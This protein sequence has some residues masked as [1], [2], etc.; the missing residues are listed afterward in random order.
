[1]CQYSLGGREGSFSADY[2][3]SICCHGFES[4]LRP[5]LA[6]SCIL[7]YLKVSKAIKFRPEVAGVFQQAETDNFLRVSLS[8]PL[9]VLL[10]S[11]SPPPIEP[12]LFC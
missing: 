4:R 9:S 7:M 3:S 10:R 12:L 2:I 6:F 8:S 5:S 1:M 11:C